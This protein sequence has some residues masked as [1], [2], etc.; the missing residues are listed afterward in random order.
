MTN[1]VGARDLKV[2]T[3]DRWRSIE[4]VID[5]A[6]ELPREQRSTYVRA[7]C[8]EDASLLADVEQLLAAH[9]VAAVDFDSPAAERFASL[10]NG[11]RL[12]LPEVLGGRYK[13]GPMLGRGGMATV[14]LA[15][16]VRHERQVAV[17]VLH[18]ELAA[19]LGAELFLAE[20]KTTAKLHHPHI[21]PLHDSGDA[22][23]LLYYV[24]PYV[25]GGTLRGRLREEKPL[26]IDEA[27]R[28]TTEVASALDAAHR[29]GVIHRD[30]KPE[31]ILLHDGTALVADFGIALAVSAAAAARVAK[32]GLVLGTPLYMSPEQAAASGD[33]DG[34]AD[35][36]SLGVVVYEMLAHDL[37]IDAAPAGRVAAAPSPT[38]RELREE[39]PIAAD[40]VL[41]QALAPLPADR[42]STAGELAAELRRA[43]APPTSI[44]DVDGKHE[45]RLARPAMPW[46][47]TAMLLLAVGGVALWQWPRSGAT[48]RWSSDQQAVDFFNEGTTW[49]DRRTPNG[50]TH[51]ESLF[52]RA[53]ASDSNF[54]DAYA[55]LAQTYV[56]FAIGNIG[57]Y[58]PE[59]FLLGARKAAQQALVRDSTVAEAHVAM[60]M[61]SMFYDFDWAG[62]ERE[63][64]RSLQLDSRSVN[65]RTAKAVLLQY[66]G[67]FGEAV[68]VA[69]EDV[70]LQGR[71]EQPK[72]ELGRALFFDRQYAAAADQLTRILERDSTRFRAHLILGE[73][74]AEQL[75]YDSAVSEM[76]AAVRFAPS[77]SRTHAYLANA[78]ARAGR[79]A[80]ARRELAAMYEKSRDRFVP[81]FDFAIVYVGLRNMDSTFAWL[82]KAVDEHSMRPYVMDPSLEPIRSD[83][84][85]EQLLRRMHLPYR[86]AR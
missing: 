41:R 57:D 73:V 56:Q 70:W 86:P 37:P 60:A 53:I 84:R 6:L 38:I 12:N 31:N 49:F 29:R 7:A 63:V 85:Y 40:A 32:P 23:G 22:D 25:P 27:M 62:A 48:P 36:Y 43:L 11:E 8:A 68:T 65:A 78:Y 34:R 42:F 30:I 17:K 5:A 59:K 33:V 51:A 58:E 67:R 3:T 19:A 4:P 77:S 45:K 13:I 39:V 66:T 28:I 15:D 54:A 83:S 1:P 69:R 18:A 9:D 64:E 10:L 16:D 46:F 61:V 71:T 47:V 26:T 24:M 52:K 79:T 14:F 80:D 82:N 74:L 76:E 21:L 55:G 81:A 75:K 20:I 44:R 72:I 50:A 35:V 2:P